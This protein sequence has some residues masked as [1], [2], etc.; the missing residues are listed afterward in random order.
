MGA[1]AHYVTDAV[2]GLG[3]R[4]TPASPFAPSSVNLLVREDNSGVP[5]AVLLT[6][7]YPITTPGGQAITVQDAG[8]V[9]LATN[10]DYWVI[11]DA[12]GRFGGGWRFNNQGAIVLTA[13]QTYGNAWNLRPD[14]EMYFFRV[15]GNPVVPEPAALLLACGGLGGLFVFLSRYRRHESV[16]SARK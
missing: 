8:S 4:D 11:D 3:V 16:S 13:G 6:V 2:L 1:T 5:G 12:Q 14:D 15:D 10:T 7:P 9:M